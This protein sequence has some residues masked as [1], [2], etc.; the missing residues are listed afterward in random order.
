MTT[1]EQELDSLFMTICHILA[2]AKRLKK[3]GK[4]FQQLVTYEAGIFFQKNSDGHL[5]R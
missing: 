2:L 1:E 4:E 5:F 3:F